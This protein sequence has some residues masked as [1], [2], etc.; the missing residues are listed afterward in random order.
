MTLSAIKQRHDNHTRF[1]NANLG[2]LSDDAQ[3]CHADRATL[4]DLVER[5]RPWVEFSAK[6]GGQ[7]DTAKA[8]R[9]LLSETDTQ[10]NEK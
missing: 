6:H 2:M 3:R 7:T 1:G 5:M 8:A 9:A 10:E 4:I